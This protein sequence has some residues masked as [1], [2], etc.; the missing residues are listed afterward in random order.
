MKTTKLGL[1][2]SIKFIGAVL[3]SWAI[4]SFFTDVF[5]RYWI[6]YASM[7]NAQTQG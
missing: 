7:N 2:M 5:N 4:F 3:S 6:N 1:E